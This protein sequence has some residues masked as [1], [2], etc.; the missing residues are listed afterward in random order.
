M[1]LEWGFTYFRF[2]DVEKTEQPII[3]RLSIHAVRYKVMTV[4]IKKPIWTHERS[5]Q[6]AGASCAIM[7]IDLTASDD[8]MSKIR[9]NVS[10]DRWPRT[11]PKS[12]PF[13]LRES[14]EVRFNSAGGLCV[15][16]IKFCNIGG[17]GRREQGVT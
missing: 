17:E 6:S 9:E 10:R 14:L 1:A 16:K 11:G 4:A 13:S 2:F 8:C 15:P 5:A 7:E 12:N 3:A